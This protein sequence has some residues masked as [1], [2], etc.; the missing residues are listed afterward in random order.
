MCETAECYPLDAAELT[1]H[2]ILFSLNIIGFSLNIG[3][4]YVMLQKKHRSELRTDSIQTALFVTSLN[5]A[6]TSSLGLIF[7]LPAIISSSY[8]IPM[9]L[10]NFSGF[11]VTSC[12]ATSLG[13]LTILASSRWSL[14][15][16]ENGRSRFQ[17]YF[18]LFVIF[19]CFSAILMVCIASTE[20][21]TMVSTKMV[22][23]PNWPTMKEVSITILS[24]VFFA[25]SVVTAAYVSI[26]LKIRRTIMSVKQY[27]NSTVSL[28]DAGNV[29][30]GNQ[31][32][33]DF[34]D[35]IQI[36]R[37]YMTIM[38]LA[39][40]GW[41]FLPVGIILTLTSGDPGPPVLMKIGHFMVVMTEILEP[42]LIIRYKESWRKYVEKMFLKSR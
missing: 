39:L 8:Y 9:K 34:L 12:V 11:L 23:W 18:T 2:C 7:G 5:G 16:L 27:F 29:G 33:E 38:L 17:K 20:P 10:C 14:V 19:L 13:N 41:V 37:R 25:F 30:T 26:A 3:A 4:L 42:I 22:C 28:N 6:V 36:A 32:K 15:V 35:E 31:H 40:C 21:F 24:L 1:I